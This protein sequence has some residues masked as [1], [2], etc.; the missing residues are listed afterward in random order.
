MPTALISVS[1]KTGVVEFGQGLLALGWELL[2]SGGTADALRAAGLPVRD[3]AERT[4]FA[5][6]FRGR[7]KT[8]H[9]AVH[10]PLLA[11][12]VPEDVQDLKTLGVGRIDLA[13]IN[14]YP[15]RNEIRR[16]GSTRATV[17]EQ[18]DI[19]GPAMLSSAAKG[20]KIVACD[21]ADYPWILDWMRQGCPDKEA[22]LECLAAKAHFVVAEYRLDSAR[23]HG[24][25]VYD[26]LVGARARKCLYGENPWQEG[27][28]LFQTDSDDPLALDQ[29]TVVEGDP[30]YNG[31]C[32][33]DRALQT[34][35]HI[36]AAFDQSCV[37][38]A[39]PRTRMPKIAVACKHGNPCGAGYGDTAQD[40]VLR[41]VRGDPRAIFGALVMLNF[42]VDETVAD[43]M[44][45]GANTGEGKRLLDAVVAHSFTEGA[46][47][48][49]RRKEN[50]CRLFGNPALG[51]LNSQSLDAAPRFRYVRGGFLLQPNY[52]FNLADA[53]EWTD[54]LATSSIGDDL[55][56]AWAI[57]ATSNSN[58]TT[59]VREKML[60]GNGVGQQDRVGCCELAVRLAQ[61]AQH[62]TTG[63]VACTDSFFPFPDGPEVLAIAGVA[64]I[65]ACSGSVRDEEVIAF[66][67]RRKV[68]LHLVPYKIGR[69]FYAH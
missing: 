45:H 3:V 21:P 34:I 65:L 31:Y 38:Y 58:T 11:E 12:D 29:F 27:A 32:D 18:T 1:D 26:G 44:L 35:T 25:G 61:N 43:A 66:C 23:F 20:G 8:L 33:F 69:G 53:D 36:A 4:G 52:T 28:A 48:M 39:L 19:G 2:A 67:K 6:L 13:C 14:L 30:S 47:T 54:R 63:S 37:R 15:L 16:T 17:I 41:M 68:P 9:P 64:A 10:G 59:L 56:L 5:S 57:C 62:E 42:T 51:H 50:K 49:L 60:I 40:A 24:G 7:V 22:R 55:L 46:V